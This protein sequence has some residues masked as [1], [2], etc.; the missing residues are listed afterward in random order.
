MYMHT[1]CRE[2]IMRTYS[3]I[4]YARYTQTLCI[5][6]LCRRY[7]LSYILY[8]IRTLCLLCAHVLHA[9][10]VYLSRVLHT[11][12][13]HIMHVSYVYCTCIYPSCS[14]YVGEH[15]AL[16]TFYCTARHSVVTPCHKF[17]PAGFAF[18]NQM[19]KCHKLGHVREKKSGGNNIKIHVGQ[20]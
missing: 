7:Y 18:R 17:V 16:K 11:Y 12:I 15:V 14:P 5:H 1:A 4:Y 13:T 6:P 2:S 3:R 8:Y 20:V 9:Y 10:Y 19:K